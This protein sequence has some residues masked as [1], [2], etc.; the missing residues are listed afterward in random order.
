MPCFQGIYQRKQAESG[1]FIACFLP[2][3][4]GVQAVAGLDDLLALHALLT[5][6]L[7]CEIGGILCQ[8]M[9]GVDELLRMRDI[10][11]KRLQQLPAGLGQ[12]TLGLEQ[13][14]GITQQAPQC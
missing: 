4:P 13:G 2:G 11:I 14:I 8:D 10:L 6:F 1:C 7:F 5:Q 9:P 3:A 12:L